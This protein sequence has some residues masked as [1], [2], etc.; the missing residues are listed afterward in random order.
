MLEFIGKTG[1]SEM[2]GKISPKP[3]D[4]RVFR[5]DPTWLKPGIN[6]LT[7]TNASELDRTIVRVNLGLW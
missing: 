7:I 6:L 5:C 1:V 3:E 4:C 2:W